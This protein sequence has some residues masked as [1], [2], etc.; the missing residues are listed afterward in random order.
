MKKYTACMLLVSFLLL[1]TCFLFPAG[2]DNEYSAANY[3]DAS[4]NVSTNRVS[5]SSKR[6]GSG[7]G[8]TVV[9]NAGTSTAVPFVIT[10]K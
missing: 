7:T 1:V 3:T 2:D 10:W 5:N 9:S 8:A 6:P 4:N